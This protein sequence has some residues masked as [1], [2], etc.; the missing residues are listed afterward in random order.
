M[1][2]SIENTIETNATKNLKI[3]EKNKKRFFNYLNEKTIDEKET[4]FKRFCNYYLFYVNGFPTVSQTYEYKCEKNLLNLEAYR[5]NIY[6]NNILLHYI[7]KT[8]D[9]LE[10]IDEF[11]LEYI[12]KDS[13]LINRLKKNQDSEDPNNIEFEM[14]TNTYKFQKPTNPKTPQHILKK[15]KKYYK[16]CRQTILMKKKFKIELTK[17]N[18]SYYPIHSENT[19]IKKNKFEKNNCEKNNIVI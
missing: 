14:V 10:R 2:I 1:Q 15:K 18:F 17:N 5:I 4:V 9:K 7:D 8:Y 13:E 19:K 12:K 16:K 3:F 11:E 6:Y